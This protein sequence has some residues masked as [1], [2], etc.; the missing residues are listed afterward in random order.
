MA[1]GARDAVPPRFE[2]DDERDAVIQTL[3]LALPEIPERVGDADGERLLLGDTVFERTTL[4]VRVGL[5]VVDTEPE[6]NGDRESDVDVDGERDTDV[7][8]LTDGVIVCELVDER[9]GDLH[10]EFVEDGV[11]VVV[12]YHECVSVKRGDL[13]PESVPEGDAE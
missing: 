8:T 11:G 10:A 2:P 1:E 3:E 12:M 4:F 5:L 9:E 7:L 13:E 6:D